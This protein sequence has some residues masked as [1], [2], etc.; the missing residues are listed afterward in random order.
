MRPQTQALLT[1]LRSMKTMTEPGTAEEVIWDIAYQQLYDKKQEVRLAKIAARLTHLWCSMRANEDLFGPPEPKT[2]EQA[3]QL[4]LGDTDI[5]GGPDLESQAMKDSVKS[6]IMLHKLN[7]QIT[8]MG[9]C[10][11]A[12]GREYDGFGEWSNHVRIRI[13]HVMKNEFPP[14]GTTSDNS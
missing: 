2:L 11:C 6:T 12:C 10:I 1:K 8:S 3:A 14:I 5:A 7:K 4:P 13:W 9:T